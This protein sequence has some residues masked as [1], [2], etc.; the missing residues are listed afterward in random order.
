MDN[1][2]MRKLLTIKSFQNIY[3]L[4]NHYFK[5]LIIKIKGINFRIGV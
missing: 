2:I 4:D 3:L 5:D 1:Q